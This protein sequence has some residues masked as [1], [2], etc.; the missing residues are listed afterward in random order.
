[1]N[2]LSEQPTTALDS[3]EENQDKEQNNETFPQNNIT[4]PIIRSKGNTGV[5]GVLADY[6]SQQELNRIENELRSLKTSWKLKQTAL[7]G[8]IQNSVAEKQENEGTT[9]D[10]DQF[11][12]DDTFIQEYRQKRM[13][14]LQQSQLPCFGFV[15]GICRD[16]FVDCIDNESPSTFVVIH[17]YQDY[18]PACR[19]VNKYMFSLAQKYRR[20]KFVKI[21]SSEADINYDDIA[22]PTLLVYKA[23]QLFTCLLRITDQIGNT[24]D[25]DHLETL[26]IKN[27]VLTL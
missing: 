2:F 11:L 6:A 27:K 5:K 15:Q 4:Q 16:Q 25:I 9:S 1:M 8:T 10:D 19:K 24:F 3:D 18:I 20:V 13:I 14:E 22:L 12:E 23:G 7:S 21:V 26:L 17:L